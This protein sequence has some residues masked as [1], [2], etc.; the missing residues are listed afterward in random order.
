MRLPLLRLLPLL[1]AACGADAAPPDIVDLQRPSDIA[2]TCFGDLRVTNGQP[3]SPD[4]DILS[5]A[6]PVSSCATWFA[7]QRP[8]GQEDLE[9]ETV[10]N[11]HAP[12]FV[13]FV[14]V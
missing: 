13:N 14:R 7:G 6:Q 5:S 4:Q 9:G 12:S 10:S 8:P 11:P 2:F 3:A 1:A